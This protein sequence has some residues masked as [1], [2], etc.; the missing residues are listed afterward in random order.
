[1]ASSEVQK[2][3]SR[4]APFA[5][6]IIK[7][8]KMQAQRTASVVLLCLFVVSSSPARLASTTS[9]AGG[10]EGTDFRITVYDAKEKI[11]IGLACGEQKSII[12]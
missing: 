7:T 8:I 9:T 5:P 12:A 1:M 6:L 10:K 2:S 4:W 11:P 3:L